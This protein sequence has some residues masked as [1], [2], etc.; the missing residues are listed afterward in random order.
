MNSIESILERNL[1]PVEAPAEL[2]T[3]V[4]DGGATKPRRDYRGLVWA[5]A[6]VAIVVAAWSVNRP[7]AIRSSEP[8]VIR[9]W[10]KTRAGV[11]IPLVGGEVTGAQA[12]RGTVRVAY[13]V[14]GHEATAFRSRRLDGRAIRCT[15]SERRIRGR[16]RF[17]GRWAGRYILWLVRSPES[18]KRAAGCAT[19]RW[20]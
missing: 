13:R 1:G 2:W 9:A 7:D 19:R 20:R 10:A 6:A 11:E 3:R 14:N 15:G 5:T 8:A 12:R 4:R 18:W 16:A 17:H